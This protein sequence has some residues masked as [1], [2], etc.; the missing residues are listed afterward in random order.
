MDG[1]PACSSGRANFE[2]EFLQ[3]TYLPCTLPTPLPPPKHKA[4][5]EA[6]KNFQVC[7]LRS[8]LP[9]PSPKTAVPCRAVGLDMGGGQ[10][11]AG[12]TG[13]QDTIKI[14]VPKSALARQVREG[15]LAT[16]RQ[17]GDS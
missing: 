16:V 9:P 13:K 12:G 10:T 14:K 11:Q 4:H 15:I 17:R 6:N 1:H 5:L 2:A 3:P 7:W 8:Y